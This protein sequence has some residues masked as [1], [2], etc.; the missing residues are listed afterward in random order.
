[1][2]GDLQMFFGFRNEK[3]QHFSGDVIVVGQVIREIVVRQEGGVPCAR[4]GV[5]RLLVDFS[6]FRRGRA[7]ERKSVAVFERSDVLNGFFSVGADLQEIEFEDRYG[8][9]KELRQW[10]IRFR[11]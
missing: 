6:G 4:P 7:P 11:A 8:I 5:R 2:R 10:A 9:R 3:V 1:M